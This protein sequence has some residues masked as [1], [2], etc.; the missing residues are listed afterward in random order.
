MEANKAIY[1][2][3]FLRQLPDRSSL[4]KTQGINKIVM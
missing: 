2:K 4:A 3:I 1:E